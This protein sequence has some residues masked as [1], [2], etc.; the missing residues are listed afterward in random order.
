MSDLKILEIDIESVPHEAVTFGIWKQTISPKN[1]TKFGYTMC[2]AAKW[3]GKHGVMFHSEWD[4]GMDKMVQA[5]WDLLNE[6]D[7]IISYNGD[8]FDVPML[9]KEFLKHG[10]LPP[11]PYHQIDLIK[12]VKRE[13]RFPGG[14]SLDQ[15]LRF[16][17]MKQ[18]ISHKGIDL[19]IECMNSEPKALAEMERY[20]KRDVTIMEALYKRL[21]PWI[22]QHPN[23]AL[24]TDD[25]RPCC[26]KCGCRK[27]TRQGF[28]HTKTQS[29]QQFKCTK[30]GSWSRKRTTALAPDKREGVLVTT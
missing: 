5:A 22:K 12:T 24:Y 4:G 30:C 20:N 29:Y 15:V 28:K 8:R 26:P 19:W 2:F 9:N 13:F 23:H 1:I 25:T 3:F 14:N 7:A 21:L 17:G 16:L 27:L 10:L 6:A 18:K 11:E